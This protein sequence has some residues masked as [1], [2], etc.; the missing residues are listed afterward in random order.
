[1]FNQG[2]FVPPAPTIPPSTFITVVANYSALPDPATVSGDFY[3]CEASQGTAWL[4]GSLGGTYYSA[5]MYYSNGITWEF[6]AVPYQATQAAVNAGIITDQFVTPYTL[7]N[8]SGRTLGTVTSVATAGL[9]SGGTITSTGTITTSMS[10]NKLVGRGTAGLGIMEE[11]TLGTG[12]SLSGTTLNST[13]GTVTTVSV[14][15]NQG[16]SGSVATATTT[17]A[18]TLS[19]GALTGVTS[20]NGLIVTANTG[21]ITTGTWNGS[22]ITGTYGGTGVNNGASTI[23]IGGNVTFSGAFTTAFTITA[24]TSVTLPTSGTILSTASVLTGYTSGSGTISSADTYI[25]AIQK[26]NGNAVAQL[27]SYYTLIHS[28]L[29]YIATGTAATA[30]TVIQSNVQYPTST[31]TGGASNVAPAA[32]YIAAADYPSVNGLTPKL[33]IRGNIFTN[34]VAPTGNFTFGLYPITAPVSAGGAGLRSHTIGTV[35]TGSD[36]ATQTTPAA[37]T[38]YNL[39]GSD[40]AL[41]ADGWYVVCILTTGTIA[42]SSFVECA[43]D[44]QITYK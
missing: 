19:L 4:P 25:G 43:A 18:I 2:V 33:R 28:Q 11:I 6:M 5:G 41:P 3:W 14:V 26:L 40:F 23:T 42:T 38:N 36:G 9:I 39:V 13:G 34:A 8:W 17:P 30:Y 31:V 10:T 7:A 21:V 22:L 24:N 37:N 20:L 44:L 15:T 27:A 35:V 29:N 32:I 1:M 12:L 16:V